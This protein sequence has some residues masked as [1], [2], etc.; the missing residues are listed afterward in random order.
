MFF[1]R[2]I[3]VII[4]VVISIIVV[5]VSKRHFIKSITGGI[6]QCEKPPVQ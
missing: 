3:I 5:L 6:E 2:T 4:E 1:S